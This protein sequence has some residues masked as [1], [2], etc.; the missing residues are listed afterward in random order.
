MHHQRSQPTPFQNSAMTYADLPPQKEDVERQD[1]VARHLEG[2][3]L[4]ATTERI[5]GFWSPS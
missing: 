1:A 2:V 5:E 4:R 3:G